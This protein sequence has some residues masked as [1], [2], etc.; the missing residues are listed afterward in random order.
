[1]AKSAKNAE[2]G[3]RFQRRRMIQNDSDQKIKAVVLK[4]EHHRTLMTLA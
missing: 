2:L 1:M 3:I 4:L